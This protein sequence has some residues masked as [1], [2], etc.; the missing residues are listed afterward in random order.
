MRLNKFAA[1]A[2]LICLAAPV[3]AQTFGPPIKGVCLLSRA[4]AINAARASQSLKVELEKKKASLSNELA[5]HRAV[6]DE[7]RRILDA[8]QD[9]IAPIEYQ[10]QRSALDRRMQQL[11]Q[12]LNARFITAQ[13]LGQRQVDDALN[14]ALARVI[15]QSACSFVMERDHTYGW[16]NAMDITRAVTQEMDFI[17]T[18]VTVP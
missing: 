3:F 2:G 18:T 17:L 1:A 7:Q 15:T 13:T 10:S 16:N 4:S 6:I 5:K 11:E 14:Q 12:Q 8:R 9:R